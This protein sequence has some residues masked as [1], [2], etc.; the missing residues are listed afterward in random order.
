MFFFMDSDDRLR[1]RSLSYFMNRLRRYGSD[2]DVVAGNSLACKFNQPVIQYEK[3][4]FYENY[5]ENGLSKLLIREVFH[6]VWNKLI[7]RNFL[8]K[9]KIIF[10][11]GIIDEDLLWSYFVFLH[12]NRILVLPK[13]TYI[14]ED[15]PKSIMNTQSQ[16][17]ASIIESRIII[18]NQI[19]ENPPKRIT[20]E[21][22]MF[23]FY[24]LLR[25]IDLYVH[26]GGA[27]SYLKNDLF[28]LRD[29]LLKMVRK[30]R[31]Y[32]LYLFFMI[33]KKPL[34]YVMSSGLFRRY[35]DK[36]AYCVL[37]TNRKFCKE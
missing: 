32:V 21:Y 24:V 18:C 28:H 4:H 26:S 29:H 14:Y 5:D 23:I 37:T 34:Y 27:F 36:I 7:K 33:S 1:P 11:K 3:E 31:Y 6:T 12:A 22:Y 13:I 10:E 20:S 8:I 25:A 16:R 17:V 2:V 15:N 9:N 30:E 19:I 35:Y